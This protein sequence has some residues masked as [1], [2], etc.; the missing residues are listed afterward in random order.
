[1]KTLLLGTALVLLIILSGCSTPDFN[2]LNDPVLTTEKLQAVMERLHQ[3]NLTVGTEA[4]DLRVYP[5]YAGIDVRNGRMLIEKFLC[6]DDCPRVG[7]VFLIY[8]NVNTVE[9]CDSLVL[10][11]PLIS[12][13][14][15][16]GQYWGC[17]PVV[18]WLDNPGIPSG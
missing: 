9:A 1:M 4:F 18:D 15:I 16:P 3:T 8:E 10:G 13:E 12:P 11:A 5:V 6:W 17:R 2:A 14:P 7:M